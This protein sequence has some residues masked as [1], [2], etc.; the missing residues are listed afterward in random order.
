MRLA[1][2][3]RCRYGCDFSARRFRYQNYRGSVGQFRF[4]QS[5]VR[6][7]TGVGGQHE[8]LTLYEYST[9]PVRGAGTSLIATSTHGGDT[10]TIGHGQYHN[11]AL[12]SVARR[13]PIKSPRDGRDTE[14]FQFGDFIR[15]FVHG[16]LLK[17]IR[18]NNK[19]SVDT[20]RSL[21]Q[22]RV[23]REI[24]RLRTQ[25]IRPAWVRHAHS[26]TLCHDCAK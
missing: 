11:F 10:S 6:N 24:P 25:T 3:I 20:A 13:S 22:M 21:F 18:R 2:H 4:A 12:L 19:W 17:Y 15:Q 14:P 8:H 16:A 23:R 5:Y 26:A 9:R 7:F 1:H